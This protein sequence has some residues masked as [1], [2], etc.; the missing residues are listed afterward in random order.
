[1][2]VIPMNRLPH[3]N[4]EISALGLA[5]AITQKRGERLSVLQIGACDGTVGDPLYHQIRRGSPI[6]AT[7]VEPIPTNF[8][9][10]KKSYEGIPHVSLVNAAV[11]TVDGDATIYSVKDE[12][13]WMGSKWAPQWASFSH[14]HLL[15]HGVYPTEIESQ[16]VQTLTLETLI[17]GVKMDFVEFLMIDTEGFDGPVLSMALEMTHLPQ[18]ICFEHLHLKEEEV[19]ALY[20]SLFSMNYRWIHD[21]MNT[22]AIKLA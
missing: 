9:R 14:E 7:L 8:E 4:I 13:R 20:N 12:G 6:K 11:G 1:M 21:R 18:F 22:L 19:E 17:K 2:S 15:K 5:F 10:L 16:T 3:S